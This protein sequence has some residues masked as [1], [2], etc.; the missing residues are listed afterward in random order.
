MKT[1]VIEGGNG[2]F[3]I[4]SHNGIN[5]AGMNK[6]QRIEYWQ[7]QGTHAILDAAWLMIQSYCAQTGT[8]PRIDRTFE[9]HSKTLADKQ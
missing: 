1:L 7:G 8:N 4:I 5:L 3:T 9:F 2:D 6:T